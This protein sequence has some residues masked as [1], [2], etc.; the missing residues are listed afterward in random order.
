MSRT[1][2]GS[3]LSG[4]PTGF[5][6]VVLCL[7]AC[8]VIQ[9]IASSDESGRMGREITQGLRVTELEG[10]GSSSDV[11]HF[12][13]AD[14]RAIRQND[15]QSKKRIGDVRKEP[16]QRDSQKSL[17]DESE[18]SGTDRLLETLLSDSQASVT[19]DPSPVDTP[20][21]WLAL[22]L[23]RFCQADQRESRGPE[24]TVDIYGAR[25]EIEASLLTT[26]ARRF[27][28]GNPAPQH[29]TITFWTPSPEAQHWQEATIHAAE[30]RKTLLNANPETDASAVITQSSIWP[31]TNRP[32][33]AISVT[34]N[35][36]FVKP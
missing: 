3:W 5:G 13:D 4:L 14:Q 12:I 16:D 17:R 18:S 20:L 27:Q 31:W 22:E 30:F 35:A 11:L 25:E 15:S 2:T 24:A 34:M 19:E 6:A 7:S 32:C 21:S 29:L 23:Q 8:V 10:D 33:P 26:M 28:S 1:T 36:R 9:A